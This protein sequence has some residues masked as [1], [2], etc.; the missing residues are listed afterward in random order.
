MIGTMMKMAQC[1]NALRDGLRGLNTP[2]LF[3]HHVQ[4]NIRECVANKGKPHP[5][6]AVP[7]LVNANK[8]VYAAY[9]CN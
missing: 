5:S 7:H 8:Q 6:I 2:F 4:A 3:G 9:K 1:G